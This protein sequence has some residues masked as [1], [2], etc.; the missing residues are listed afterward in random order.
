MI[1]VHIDSTCLKTEVPKFYNSLI[2]ERLK[3]TPIISCKKLHSPNE[4]TY[5]SHAYASRGQ[6]NFK[7]FQNCLLKHHPKDNLSNYAF[8]I[9]MWKERATN[10]ER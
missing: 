1:R 10:V 3:L 4:I 9:S 2:A 7:R 6:T 5:R 8:Y